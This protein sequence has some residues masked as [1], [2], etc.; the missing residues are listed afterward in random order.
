M[1]GFLRTVFA[2]VLIFWFNAPSQLISKRT[3]SRR[4]VFFLQR[5]STTNAVA[6]HSAPKTEP[7]PNGL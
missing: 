6:F 2:T 4:M 5:R 3:P 7:E 1:S